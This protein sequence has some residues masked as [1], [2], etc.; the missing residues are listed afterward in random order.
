MI[1]SISHIPMCMCQSEFKLSRAT[2]IPFAH[3][4]YASVTCP[5]KIGVSVTC[6]PTTCNEYL[7]CIVSLNQPFK[8]V[9]FSA[10]GTW[11]SC[12]GE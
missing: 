5:R 8:V 1:F 9:H 12:I 10:F 3:S 7:M 11:H 4:K 2:R 6:K